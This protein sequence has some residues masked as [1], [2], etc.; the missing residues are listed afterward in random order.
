[1]AYDAARRMTVLFGGA[2]ENN[3]QEDAETW[4]WDGYTWN[5][6]TPAVSPPA[7]SGA[8]LA[9]H[10]PTKTLVLF[11]GG[12]AKG[13]LGDTWL[14]DGITWTAAPGGGPPVRGGASMA[15]DP[16]SGGLILVGGYGDYLYYDTWMWNG[17]SWALLSDDL[18]YP[19]RSGASLA[20]HPGM[21]RLILFG[22]AGSPM[23][24]TVE[25][26]TWAWDGT[27][28]SQLPL[29]SEPPWRVE[30]VMAESRGQLLLFGG[31]SWV[32]P[33]SGNWAYLGDT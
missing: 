28:W 32:P 6:L 27:N 10:P 33:G 29:D 31:M 7:R 9:Y 1:M 16:P 25:E 30:A 22:G 18:G 11:G 17:K 14:W 12:S 3:A 8:S 2:H 5:H 15:L 23:G 24:H 13:F 26:G 19:P 20:Y 4:A 21:G